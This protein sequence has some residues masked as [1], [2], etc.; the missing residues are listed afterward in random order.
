VTISYERTGNVAIITIDRQEVRNALDI[1]ARTELFEA[2]SRFAGDRDSSVAILTGAGTEAFC[3][4]TD[5]RSAVVDEEPFASSYFGER[6]AATTE[7]W[8]PLDRLWKPVLAAINGYALGGGM[9][10]S[11]ACDLRI[12]SSNARF[13]QPEAHVGSMVGGGASVRLMRAIP[14]A[15]A[16]KMLL[17]GDSID[18][19][20]AYRAGLVSDVVPPEE[21][22][23]TALSIAERICRNG[24]L[25]VRATKMSAVLGQS[26][27]LEHAMTVER[28]LWGILRDSS[29]RVEGRQAFKERREPRFQG[30]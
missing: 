19:Q 26:L 14:Q 16:M 28:L 7:L 21:L 11:L 25:A 18:A 6:T 5:L 27:P 13:G 30:R 23:S 22:L 4:G 3:A 2:W 12:A 17:T 20:E 8:R 1:E 10:L 15:L 24:P 29:D 9:E